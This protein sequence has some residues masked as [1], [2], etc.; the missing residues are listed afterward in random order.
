MQ[1]ISKGMLA[2]LAS[3][4]IMGLADGAQ[5]EDWGRFYHYPYSYYPVNFRQPF[6]SRDFDTSR[7]GYPAYP[8]YM[9]FPPY[10]RKDLFYPYMTPL[11]MPG[12]KPHMHHQGN[13]YVLDIF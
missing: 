6:R 7:T 1:R 10:Y 3:I 11:R 12:N 9:G 2:L 5:A 13:H 4:V 8:A